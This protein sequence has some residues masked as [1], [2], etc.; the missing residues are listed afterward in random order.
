M[1]EFSWKWSDWSWCLPNSKYQ[2]I[3][4]GICTVI[5]SHTVTKYTV[6]SKGSVHPDTL[7]GRHRTSI[8]SN[9]A[10]NNFQKNSCTTMSDVKLCQ[11]T[12]PHVFIAW[13]STYRELLKQTW[14]T[15]KIFTLLG[16]LWICS[17]WEGQDRDRS[18]VLTWR[19][20]VKYNRRRITFCTIYFFRSCENIENW[21]CYDVLKYD[22]GTIWT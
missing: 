21:K 3:L 19:K 2:L 4:K 17:S 15:F 18:H 13:K 20:T 8:G 14:G 1:R 11:E 16:K 5:Q 7:E 9:F 6:I 22:F 12:I 10:T